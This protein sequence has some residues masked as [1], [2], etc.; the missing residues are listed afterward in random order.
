MG[1]YIYV[2][3]CLTMTPALQIGAQWYS[4]KV[5]GLK[6]TCYLFYLH[7]FKSQ[8]VYLIYGD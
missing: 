4:K 3:S 7:I 6:S 1:V 5:T 8:Y 2:K